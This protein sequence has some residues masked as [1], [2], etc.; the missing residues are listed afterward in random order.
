MNVS[1][2]HAMGNLL[3]ML[4]SIRALPRIE[5]Y[6]HWTRRTQHISGKVKLYAKNIEKNSKFSR[7]QIPQKMV[8]MSKNGPKTFFQSPRK[9]FLWM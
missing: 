1:D 4:L 7:C 3:E 6:D 8:K 5:N 2:A 9:N